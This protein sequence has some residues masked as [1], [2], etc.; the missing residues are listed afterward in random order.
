MR[1]FLLVV[2]FAVTSVPASRGTEQDKAVLKLALE[3]CGYRI[4]LSSVA[5]GFDVATVRT[6]IR[7]AC[8]PQITGLTQALSSEHGPEMGPKLADLT[9]DVMMQRYAEAMRV[10]NPSAPLKT[11]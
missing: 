11:R 8:E 1:Q 7:Q 9:V 5:Y 10:I 3:G 4:A 6:M 2:F